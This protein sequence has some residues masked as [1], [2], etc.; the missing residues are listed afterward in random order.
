MNSKYKTVVIITSLLVV[1]S[2]S[3]SIINYLV[4]LNN[5]QE[6]LKTQSL[7]LSLDNIYTDIQKH[8]IQ[9]YLVSSMM[10]NDTF[11]QDWLLH[12]EQDSKKI[13]KYLETIKN[14]YNMFNTFLVSDKTKNYYTQKGF[15]ET[16]KEDQADNKWYF[17]F[18]NIQNKHEINLDFNEHLSNNLIMFINYKILD[19]NFQFLGAT[20]VAL[21]ISYIN[22]MLKQF[23]VNHNFIVTF[24]NEKGDVVLAEKNILKYKNIDEI[25][26]LKSNKDLIL[27]KNTYLIEYNKKGSKY[28]LNTKYIPELDLYLTVEA[29]LEDFTKN[30]K[31]IFYINIIISL[32][33]T[34]IIALIVYFVIKNYSSKLEYL[35]NNDTLTNI[36]NRRDFEEKL[37]NLLLL[38]KRNQSDMSIIFIDID[39]FKSINDQFGHHKGDMV[40]KRAAKILKENIRQT[41]LIARWGGEEFIIALIDSTLENSQTVTQKLRKALENDL[42]LQNIAGYSITGSFGLTMVQESD[43]Q[44]QLIMRS[45][46][47]MYQSKNNGKN[48]VT[49]I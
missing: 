29:N 39:N 47:A 44:E 38:Q 45:D 32:L 13:I 12:E 9:P 17:N 15:I 40:L 1:L 42:E 31:K 4:S 7:P 22:D 28:I 11:V 5:A 20:G 30:V 27:S 24:F 2:V 36:S 14:K 33:I 26:E 8:I 6:Q 49:V 16:I 3:I 25:A 18:K 43:T 23:R 41:D 19:G 35:S 46:K 37:Q 34:I 10:A 21:K 48:K